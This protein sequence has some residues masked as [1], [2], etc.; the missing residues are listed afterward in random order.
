MNV[1]HLVQE[2]TSEWL[3][4]KFDDKL[5]AIRRN[6]MIASSIVIA[7]TFINPPQSG[8]FEVN[9][10]LVKGVLQNPLY[11][12]YFL[13]I[14]CLY[15][16]V[17]F[18]IHCRYVAAQNYRDIKHRFFY[19]LAAHRAKEAYVRV[20]SSSDKNLPQPPE[21]QPTGGGGSTSEWG[22]KINFVKKVKLEYASGLETLKENGFTISEYKRELIV[23]YSYSPVFE[24]FQ[25]LKIHL[26]M[27]WRAKWSQI[28]TTV[29]PI[30]YAVLALILLSFNIYGMAKS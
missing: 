17:W 4:Y 27:F 13:A 14:S 2:Q 1:Y 9:I 15:Y 6:L 12:Y 5:Y 19:Y 29:I 28:F 16:L 8:V 10:G 25:Y 30:A 24:D 20:Y 21:F 18:Y 22:S 11:L 26:D 7:S 3:N 23:N